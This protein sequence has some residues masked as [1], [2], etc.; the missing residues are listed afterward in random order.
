[1]HTYMHTYPML[2]VKHLH[3]SIHTYI[4]TYIRTYKHKTQ[5][6][7][8]QTFIDKDPARGV[9]PGEWPWKSSCAHATCLCPTGMLSWLSPAS[10][11]LVYSALYFP[12]RHSVSMIRDPP[13]LFLSFCLGVRRPNLITGLSGWRTPV[14]PPSSP[15]PFGASPSSHGDHQFLFE[16]PLQAFV[17]R[18]PP[19]QHVANSRLW[20]A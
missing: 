9:V 7:R 12:P 15:P 13:P 6:I 5:C 3:S 1:M 19:L 2:Y 17:V 10:Y 18:K 8:T 14:S 4:L 20:R 16:K 11:L